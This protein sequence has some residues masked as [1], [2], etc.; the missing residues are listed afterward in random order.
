MAWSHLSSGQPLNF[1]TAVADAQ[2]WCA[3][4]QKVSHIYHYLDAYSHEVPSPG[5][6]SVP[7]A[8][9]PGAPDDRSWHM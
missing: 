2:E 8:A 6:G 9:T 5:Q 7:K 3:R 4:E 1:F